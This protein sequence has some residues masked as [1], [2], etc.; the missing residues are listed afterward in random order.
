MEEQSK[1]E[2]QTIIENYLDRAATRMPLLPSWLVSR[3]HGCLLLN[4]PIS[5]LAR[6]LRWVL[7]PHPHQPLTLPDSM[8]LDPRANKP[9]MLAVQLLRT[10]TL[11]FQVGKSILYGENTFA[12][13]SSSTSYDLDSA[14]ARLKGWQRQLITSISLQIDWADELWAKFP[15]IAVAL[16]DLKKLKKLEIFLVS[17]ASGGSGRLVR[18]VRNVSEMQELQRKKVRG[19][20]REG[21]AAEI[22]L[23]AEKKTFKD[24]VC[25]MRSL[26]VFRLVGFA[27]EEFARHLEL[28]VSARDGMGHWIDGS[29]LK[30]R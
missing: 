1:L 17:K 12:A 6:I 20:K 25:T 5:V 22:L 9:T 10:C 29:Y 30:A 11:I 24:L 7:I 14:L 26:R 3:R 15:L 27:D 16:Y 28:Q 13:S 18:D 21:N 23:K 2:R 19:L 8:S 4:L